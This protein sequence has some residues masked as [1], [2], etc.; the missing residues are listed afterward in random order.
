MEDVYFLRSYRIGNLNFKSCNRLKQNY[1][2]IYCITGEVEQ[3]S[4]VKQIERKEWE[5][6]VKVNKDRK[7]SM[8][9][10]RRQV[11]PKLE[12][13]TIHEWINEEK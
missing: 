9:V 5:I 11:R 3:I 8:D 7:T 10:V 6:V 4:V 13:E 2:C 12:G 1:K